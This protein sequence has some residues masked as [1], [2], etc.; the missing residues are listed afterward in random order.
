MERPE[1]P[2]PARRARS[3]LLGPLYGRLAGLG[4]WQ[5]CLAAFFLGVVSVLAFPPFFIWPALALGL[6]GLVWLLDGAA[7]AER[8]Q[9]AAFERVFCFGFGCFLAGLY[10]IVAAFLVDPGAHLVFIWLPL[11]VLPA[12]LALIPAFAIGLAFRFWRPGPVRL[13]LFTLAFMLA[14]LLRAELFGLGGLPW[15]LPAMVWSPGGPMSQSASLWGVYGLSLLTVLAMTAP[16]ALADRDGRGGAL[17]AAPAL[18]AAVL[19]G[20]LWGWGAQRLSELPGE[21]E[22]VRVRLVEA[23]VPQNR[24]FEAG[25]GAEMVRRFI[26]LS[27]ADGPDAAEIVIWP[28]GALPYYL[29]E[30]PDALE[31]ITEPLGRRRLIIGLARRESIG[32]TDE[33]A[34]NSLAV[35]SAESGREGPLALYDKHRLVPFGEFT[36]FEELARLIGVR[37]LQE[38][39]AGGFEAGPRPASVRADGIRPFGALICYEAI[40]PGLSPSG[41]DRPEWLVNISNDAW[42]GGL[43]GPHQ[44]AAQARYRSIE[45]GL[46]MARVASGGSTGLIDAYGRW[47]VRGEAPDTALYGADPDGWRSRVAEGRIP[48]RLEPTVYARWG[49][50]PVWIMLAALGFAALAPGRARRRD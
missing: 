23:G 17:R 28:E 35:L 38:L 14:E 5:A 3:D 45:E 43:T 1:R 22:G 41:E 49:D 10:W 21:G 50:W 15:N 36:P 32:E 7:G 44:H 34:Y 29:F 31:A 20:V 27:G 13:L 12:G 24:K 37:T 11:I 6:S 39:A 4:R 9:R 2:D 42:F 47:T 40:F 30:W 48:P 16:A 25:V 33:R 8:P 18:A 46:P 26:E 19:A